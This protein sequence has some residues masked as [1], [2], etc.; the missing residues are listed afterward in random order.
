M[1]KETQQDKPKVLGRLLQSTS[2]VK[3]EVIAQL[4][5]TEQA[6]LWSNF[7]EQRICQ[8]GETLRLEMQQTYEKHRSEMQQIYEQRHR[9]MRFQAVYQWIITAALVLEF[10]TR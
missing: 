8:L 1:T 2:G 7:I 4:A 5:S 3:S 6:E 10:I 9:E